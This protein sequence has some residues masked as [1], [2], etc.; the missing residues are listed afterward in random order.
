MF[1]SMSRP[2]LMWL[3]SEPG[4]AL[5]ERSASI[6]FEHVTQKKQIGDGH[7]V[8]ILPGFLSSQSSTKALRKYVANL[9]YEVF[10]W[11]LGRN[12]GKLEY[13]ELLLERLDE[14]YIKTGR[15]VSI[16][17]WSLGGVFARQLAKERPNITRQV[18]TLAAPFIGLSEPNNIAWIYSLLNYGKKV[19]DVNQ[20]LLEDLPRPATVP[21]TAIYSKS[22]GVVPWKYCIEPIEDDIHQNIEVRSSH[23]GMGVNLAVFAVIE[24]RLLY[25]KESWV[26]FRPRGIMNNRLM[27]PAY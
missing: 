25:E 10:D 11:G 1:E 18:I 4:R 17:G 14:I 3:L 5:I 7:P 20:T 8:M 23:I 13:M 21:T 16:I 19:K 15:E 22:D 9:G 24:D 6:P 2:S 26:K 27:F 12:M